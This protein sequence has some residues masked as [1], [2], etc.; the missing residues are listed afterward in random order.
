[1]RIAPAF[2][3]AARRAAAAWIPGVAAGDGAAVP[4]RTL[5][6]ARVDTAA[7][8]SVFLER[9]VGVASR[10]VAVFVAAARM[11]AA[12]WIPGLATVDARASVCCRVGSKRRVPYE[13]GDSA[14]AWFGARLDGWRRP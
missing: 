4:V 3:A 6:A 8:A 11:A 10:V 14:R 13:R 12:A 5:F 9:V 1:M 2:P 7:V